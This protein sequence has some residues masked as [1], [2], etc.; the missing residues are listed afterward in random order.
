[1][2]NLISIIGKL[3]LK[4]IVLFVVGSFAI[5]LL[6]RF[7]NPPITTFMV[8][9]NIQNDRPWFQTKD[10]EWISIEKISTAMSVAVVASEDNLFFSHRGFD[11]KAIREAREQNKT[12]K[13]MRGASTITQQTA[14]NL[15]LFPHRS[16]LRKGLEAWFTFLIELCW[17]KPRIL[18]IYL[19]IIETGPNIYGVN[20]AAAAYYKTTA[21]K[22][23]KSQ[24]AMIT[25]CLPNPFK[26]KP[27]KPTKYLRKRKKQI[28]WNMDNLWPVVV[29]GLSN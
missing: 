10:R 29:E 2:K 23:S 17:D 19:N 1:M 25:A 21:E 24:A 3:L 14:K 27:N 18:E 20:S 16:Y 26:R 4:L 13:R 5:V 11:W 9:R 8:V 22:L 28:R 6:F 12:G 15:F 7:V